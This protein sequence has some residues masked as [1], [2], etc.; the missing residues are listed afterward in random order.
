MTN[1]VEERLEIEV[2]GWDEDSNSFT[3]EGGINPTLDRLIKEK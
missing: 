1:H 2:Q 3:T